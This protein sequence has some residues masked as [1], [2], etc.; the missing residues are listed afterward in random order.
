M[1]RKEQRTRQVLWL[2]CGCQG[3]RG[4]SESL[5]NLRAAVGQERA[6]AEKQGISFVCF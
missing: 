3:E 6:G 4:V 1:T 5:P 2:E